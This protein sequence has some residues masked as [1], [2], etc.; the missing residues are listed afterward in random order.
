MWNE[1]TITTAR[2]TGKD[3]KEGEDMSSMNRRKIQV[4]KKKTAAEVS[5]VLAVSLFCQDLY[6]SKMIST[7]KRA[8]MCE[9]QRLL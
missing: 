1:K 8:L 9:I 2:A 5:I 4:N 3:I 7:S 6:A